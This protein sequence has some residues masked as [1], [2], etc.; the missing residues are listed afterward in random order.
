MT[1]NTLSNI[2][3]FL[4]IYELDAFQIIQLQSYLNVAV[5]QVNIKLDGQLN[6]NTLKALMIY[7][8]RNKLNFPT[9]ISHQF[10]K[11]IKL[12]ILELNPLSITTDTLLEYIQSRIHCSELSVPQNWVV[13][14]ISFCYSFNIHTKENLLAFLSTIEYESN[15]YSELFRFRFGDLKPSKDKRYFLKYQP[16]G[17]I[18]LRHED[19]YKKFSQLSAGV[20]IVNNPYALLIPDVAIY[21][22]CLY[23]NYFK[24]NKP[25]SELNYRSVVKHFDVT[26]DSWKDRYNIWV[27]MNGN[28]PSRRTYR[29]R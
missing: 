15:Q 16:K 29:M 28:C 27:Q 13:N 25:A 6:Q 5:P 7:K 23:W 24:L 18:K 21:F 26:C 19:S 1:I 2:N 4:S 9:N 11:H 22:A 14:L 20:D 8:E 12:S 3:S 10:V 17:L